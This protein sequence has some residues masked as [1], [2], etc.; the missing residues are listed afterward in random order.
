MASL[1]GGKGIRVSVPVV[2]AAGLVWAGAP[3]HATGGATRLAAGTI[4]TAADGIGGP[5]S[6]VNVSIQACGLKFVAGAL[7]VG[8]G[9]LVRRVDPR[10]GRLSTV[11][12]GM[13]DDY[14]IEGL[15]TGGACG[16]TVDRAGNILVADSDRV[17]V[18]AERTGRFYGRKMTARHTYTLTGK[19]G[20]S[21]SV[22]NFG[23]GG[24]AAKALLS[25]AVAVELD[26]AG[27]VV[28]AD[29]GQLQEDVAPPLGALVWVVAERTG[30]FY[31]Q[32]MIAGHS[33]V[34][35]GT[36]LAASVPIGGLGTEVSL[37]WVIG[38]VRLDRAGNL[39][40]ADTTVRAVRVVA[41]RSGTFYGQKMTAGHIYDIAGGRA[42]GD[43]GPGIRARLAGPGGVA[44]DHAGN[45]IIAD[46]GRVRVLAARTGRFYGKRMITGHI[47]SIAG[48]GP[49]IGRFGDCSGLSETGDGGPASRAQI[50]ASGVT[51][52]QAG[53]V[54]IADGAVKPFG[55]GD[56]RVRAIVARAGHYYGR[57]MRAG[58]IYT[59]AGNGRIQSS[60][61][62]LLAARAE[63]SLSGVTEDHAGNLMV[64]DN[65]S[66][67]GGLVR[68]VPAA[69]GRFFGR[70]MTVGNIY[71]IAGGGRQ[72]GDGEPA[73][74]A[75][76]N[77]P[78]GLTMGRAGNL[79]IAD[80]PVRVRSVTG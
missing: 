27:N 39:V 24:P 17:R 64:I 8:G 2:A 61:D 41:A 15:G 6:A 72:A 18:V 3:A 19:K 76:L 55:L 35:A 43:G 31:G 14:F 77:S 11:A 38:Q 53:N 23:N 63:L 30:R 1:F 48:S 79:L 68:M 20:Q 36:P 29:A 26:Q 5:G 80:P 75:A 62:G 28:V 32:K 59:I 65:Y 22:V 12:A 33:Y 25:D 71:T 52:D 67:E 16:V 10:A 40:I 57:K 78:V 56:A 73:I 44:L 74:R 37:G 60:G 47:Y 69:S 49:A 51:V 50:A 4:T 70:K 45:V 58:H 7:Y 54:L 9:D 42:A 66:G 21:R 13:A 46:C 34:V